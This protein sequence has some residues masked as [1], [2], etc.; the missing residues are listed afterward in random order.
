MS[1]QAGEARARARAT[2]AAGHWDEI[3]K[4][5]PPAG[6]R[7]LEIAGVQ[8]GM[9]VVDVGCGSGGT[10]AIPAALRG[11]RVTG[12]DVTPELFD[13]ARRRQAEAGVEVDWLEGDA[14]AL[15]LPDDRFDRVLSTFGHAF[16][17]DQEGA[18]RELVRVC[19]PG[20]KIV[21]AMWTPE[22]LNGGLFTVVG[23]HMPKPP[24]GAHAPIEWGTE[25]R[26]EEL[27]GSQGIALEFRREA[28]V[29]QAPDAATYQAG[30]E[31]NFGPLVM[32]RKLL[33]EEGFAALH[34][35]LAQLYQ[36]AN[37]ATDGT[38][39]AEAEYLVAIGEKPA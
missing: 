14:A 33:G 35:D 19:T 24:P 6:E 32:A 10:I 3:S 36:D 4:M 20:G 39:R 37:Q 26:W 21:V 7:V 25:E 5:L 13:D 18:A 38:F 1:D 29:M 15:P 12:V 30:F 23:R 11:A 8:A 34:D 17:P 27:V 28:L 16:A 9:D 22:G 31:A 2:W